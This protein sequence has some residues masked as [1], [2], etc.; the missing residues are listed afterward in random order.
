MF[1]SIE[2]ERIRNHLENTEKLMLAKDYS[3]LNDELKNSRKNMIKLLH[4][5]WKAGSFPTNTEFPMKRLPHIKDVYGVPCAMAYLIEQSGDV[6]LVKELEKTNNVFIK[7][8][9]DGPLIDWIN[10]SGITKDEACQ[11]QPS[12]AFDPITPLP[13]DFLKRRGK[14]QPIPKRVRRGN[15]IRKLPERTPPRA[16]GP[17]PK[18]KTMNLRD[19][20]LERLSPARIAELK[21]LKKLRELQARGLI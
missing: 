5:Y 21:R 13:R 6:E 11:I 12:Y 18:R 10:K 4:E 9:S 17:L 20:Q 1:N 15:I 19:G 14:D 3:H 2:D 7:D 16:T 8:V